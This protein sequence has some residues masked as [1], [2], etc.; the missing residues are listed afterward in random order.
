MNDNVLN[1]SIYFAN[2]IDWK[3]LVVNVL[4]VH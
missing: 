2:Q 4:Y 1:I 3:T